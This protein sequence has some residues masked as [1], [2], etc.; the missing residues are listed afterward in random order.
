M[1]FWAVL[2]C[3]IIIAIILGVELFGREFVQLLIESGVNVPASFYAKRG[4][5]LYLPLSKDGASTS[6]RDGEVI[7]RRLDD[8]IP[9]KIIVRQHHSP[10]DAVNPAPAD[11]ALEMRFDVA[12]LGDIHAGI[13]SLVFSTHYNTGIAPMLNVAWRDQCAEPV[14][15]QTIYVHGLVDADQARSEQS[16]ALTLALALLLAH[17]NL[18]TLDALTQSPLSPSDQKLTTCRLTGLERR[19]TS[20]VLTYHGQIMQGATPLDESRI[21]ETLLTHARY[22]ARGLGDGE[23]ITRCLEH[24]E[25][26]EDTP[27]GIKSLSAQVLAGQLLKSNDQP[28]VAAAKQRF[29]ELVWQ[30]QSRFQVADM[31]KW[32][33]P[34]VLRELTD[35]QLFEHGRHEFSDVLHDALSARRPAI[36][37]LNDPDLCWGLREKVLRGV[38]REDEGL[39]LHGPPMFKSLTQVSLAMCLGFLAKQASPLLWRAPWFVKQVEAR[40]MKFETKGWS[41]LYDSVLGKEA[42]FGEQEVFTSTRIAQDVIFEASVKAITAQPDALCGAELMHYQVISFMTRSQGRAIRPMWTRLNDGLDVAQIDRV[43]RHSWLW[44]GEPFW[45]MAELS[46]RPSFS[47]FTQRYPAT[48]ELILSVFD[49]AYKR[50]QGPLNLEVCYRLIIQLE[51]ELRRLTL[52]RHEELFGLFVR[53]FIEQAE[54]QGVSAETVTMLVDL[55]T[56]ATTTNQ[57]NMINYTR[58]IWVNG[59]KEQHLLGAIT[60]V[61]TRNELAG[62]LTLKEDP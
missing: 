15:P 9:V 5:A 37:L 47:Q 19:R 6:R 13:N 17:R 8:D 18:D 16:I 50:R 60:H 59:L 30:D 12:D 33:G 23:L 14:I 2:G 22:L 38:L 32:L 46:E 58:K 31:V 43:L 48:F 20:L 29:V 57:N 56:M 4:R 51:R 49:I 45:F 24:L 36:K 1:V 21:M 55:S 7:V 53:T 52:T 54:E 34:Q 3:V 26:L 39:A 62:G 42:E 44:D 10:E 61:E 35:E 40:L 11:L 41:Q 25:F 28:W 27:P